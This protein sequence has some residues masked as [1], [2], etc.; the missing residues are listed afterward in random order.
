MSI[1]RRFNKP[2]YS[3]KKRPN[4]STIRGARKSWL[5]MTSEIDYYNRLYLEREQKLTEKQ[6]YA[7][8]HYMGAYIE[9]LAAQLNRMEGMYSLYCEYKLNPPKRKSQSLLDE[10]RG[11]LVLYIKDYLSYKPTPDIE[12]AERW[13]WI[14]Q[15]IKTELEDVKEPTEAPAKEPELSDVEKLEQDKKR[16][17]RGFRQ[18][19]YIVNYTGLKPGMSEKE[20]KQLHSDHWDQAEYNPELWTTKQGTKRYESML[21]RAEKLKG[22]RKAEKEIL[23]TKYLIL[24]NL[25]ENKPT[26]NNQQLSWKSEKRKELF[27]WFQDAE[28]EHMFALEYELDPEGQEMQTLDYNI[29][30]WSEMKGMLDRVIYAKRVKSEKIYQEERFEKIYRMTKNPDVL[31]HADVQEIEKDLMSRTNEL[32]RQANIFKTGDKQHKQIVPYQVLRNF[33]GMQDDLIRF[34]YSTESNGAKNTKTNS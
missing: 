17:E 19:G 1:S 3:I 4:A 27:R 8:Q 9:F 6:T 25:L 5:E 26:D 20:K 14:I 29:H 10:T 7:L 23:D 12:T 24:Q 28:L 21:K 18:M 33:F 2:P 32:N 30:E 34:L 13:D 16:I 11:L 15:T 22:I 31:N